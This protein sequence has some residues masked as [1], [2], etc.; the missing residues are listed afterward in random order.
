MNSVPNIH[1]SVAI[2]GASLSISLALTTVIVWMLSLW[3]IEVPADVG[4]ALSVVVTFTLLVIFHGKIPQVGAV[5]PEALLVSS[6]TGVAVGVPVVS[7]APIVSTV[8]STDAPGGQ[9]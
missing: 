4:V 9:V 5:D 2:G 3:K 7:T 6:V 8:V 1:P